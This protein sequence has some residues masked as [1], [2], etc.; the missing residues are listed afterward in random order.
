MLT[1]DQCRGLCLGRTPVER[2]LAA[3]HWRRL[4]PGL[5]RTSPGEPPWLAWAWGGVLLGGPSARLGG[6]AAAHLHGLTDPPDQVVVLVSR[7]VR[8]VSRAPWVFV[9]DRAARRPPAG[10]PPRLRVED[11]VL[12]LA[13]DLD[14]RGVVGLVTQ[15]VQTRRTTTA[16][17]RRRLHERGHVRHRALLAAL[18]GDV[19]EGAESPLELGYL[20]TVERPHGLPRGSRQL[21][22]RHGHVRDVGY[23]AYGVV[24]ELDGRLGH[25]G[26]GRFKDMWRDNLAVVV[27]EVTLRYGF[28]DVHDRPCEVAVQVAQVLGNRGWTGLGRS[29]PRCR[30]AR[31]W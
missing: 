25:E 2:L 18:L 30:S 8:R 17:L 6:A 21:R 4:T 19:A 3:G 9:Q 12:D 16:A 15:A 27:G 7:E 5:V 31:L 13:A 22:N 24:V 11:A 29:C 28:A 26:R 14:E 1:L 10:A 20:R 23:R